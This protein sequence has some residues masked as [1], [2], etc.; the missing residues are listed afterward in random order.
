MGTSC[1][2][3]YELVLF[4][5]MPHTCNKIR[6]GCKKER[7]KIWSFKAKQGGGRQ[8]A[9]S[10]QS[11]SSRQPPALSWSISY[12]PFCAAICSTRKGICSRKQRWFW[13]QPCSVFF[14]HSPLYLAISSLMTGQPEDQG[15]GKKRRGGK[16]LQGIKI[17]NTDQ[18]VLRAIMSVRKAIHWVSAILVGWMSQ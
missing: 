13:P 11:S 4:V 6:K 2:P 1:Q 8:Q 9:S 7:G 10:S 12:S 5:V 17:D 15:K 3:N 18:S 16:S 14:S